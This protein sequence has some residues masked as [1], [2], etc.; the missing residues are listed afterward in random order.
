VAF[1]ELPHEN[2]GK[3]RGIC[4]RFG[5]IKTLTALVENILDDGQVFG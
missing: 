3:S 2:N 4:T 5:N 1:L